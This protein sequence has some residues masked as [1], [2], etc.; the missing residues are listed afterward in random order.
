MYIYGF[1]VSPAPFLSFGP[2][3]FS[4][5]HPSQRATPM[6][7]CKDRPTEQKMKSLIKYPLNSR[8]HPEYYASDC[9]CLFSR[10]DNDAVSKAVVVKI[11][12]EAE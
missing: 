11:N 7:S 3:T 2:H 6:F 5:S 10:S 9:I 12:M 1:Q 4:E 8:E